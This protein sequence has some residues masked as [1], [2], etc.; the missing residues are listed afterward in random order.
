MTERESIE[1]SASDGQRLRGIY[2]RAPD[3]RPSPAVVF[4][5]GLGSIWNGEKAAALE[6]ECSRRGWA[7]A[8]CDFRGHGESDGTMLELCGS[9]LLEDLDLITSTVVERARGPLFLAGSSMGG[10][11]AA[12]FAA[13]RPERVAA[14]ALIAPAFRLFECRRLRED[15]REAWKRT[16]RHRLVNQFIDLE[17]GYGFVAE[18]GRF[19]FDSLA[20]GFRGPA[21]IFHGM[22]D[23]EVP[24]LTSLEFISACAAPDLQLLMIKDGDHRLNRDRELLARAA[25]DFFAARR[26]LL[27]I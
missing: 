21:I 20:A 12:W 16:G 27:G 26:M 7:F 4:A 8:A 9:R 25:G 14:C 24:Y 18:A 15:E 3:D 22:A 13:N 2:R 11:A 17:L 10:W 1:I 23:Q 19:G 6:A 5:H